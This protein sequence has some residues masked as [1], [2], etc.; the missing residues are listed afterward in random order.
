MEADVQ[1]GNGAIPKGTPTGL[2]AGG[3]YASAGADGASLLKNPADDSPL[4]TPLLS[5]CRPSLSGF[6]MYGGQLPMAKNKTELH[7]TTIFDGELDELYN[8]IRHITPKF[9]GEKER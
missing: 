3:I 9:E 8:A 1:P 7:V 4:H 2:H 5:R 6:F